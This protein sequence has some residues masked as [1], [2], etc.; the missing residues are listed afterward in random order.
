MQSSK[1]NILCLCIGDFEFVYTGKEVGDFRTKESHLRVHSK[2]RHTLP[3]QLTSSPEIDR[4]IVRIVT[5]ALHSA[6]TPLQTI[7]CVCNSFRSVRNAS[8]PVYIADYCRNS[9]RGCGGFLFCF[10]GCAL[11]KRFPPTISPLSP[12]L[13]SHSPHVIAVVNFPCNSFA[14]VFAAIQV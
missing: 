9:Y 6:K 4:A 3:S 5:Y 8:V 2:I 7:T 13:Y 11:S 10:S 12:P 1:H 14:K